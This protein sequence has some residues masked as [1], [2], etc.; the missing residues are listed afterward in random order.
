VIPLGQVDYKLWVIFVQITPRPENLP[1]ETFEDLHVV[2]RQVVGCECI[3]HAHVLVKRTCTHNVRHMSDWEDQWTSG[4]IGRMEG[5]LEETDKSGLTVHI[6]CCADGAQDSFYD[7]AY[8]YPVIPS[9]T[10]GYSLGVF[11]VQI[12]MVNVLRSR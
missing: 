7:R 9:I 2:T 11:L 10:L 12:A 8:I 5:D 3:L 6:S 1:D 4:H